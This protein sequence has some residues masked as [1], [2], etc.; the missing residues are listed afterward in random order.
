MFL[1][2]SFLNFFIPSAS[3]QA[4]VSMPLMVPLGDLLD[5]TR[6]TTVFIYVSGDGFSNMIIPT[7]GFLMAVLGIAGV[8]FEKWVKFIFPIFLTFFIIA[9]IFISIAVLINY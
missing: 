5:L 2:Q 7:N 4:L 8:P 6:Q 3:G 1:F 9:A